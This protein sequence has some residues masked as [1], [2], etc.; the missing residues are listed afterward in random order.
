[1]A[2]GWLAVCHRRDVPQY[3]FPTPSPGYGWR[4]WK[5]LSGLLG[6]DRRARR[7]GE[8]DAPTDPGQTTGRPTG[9]GSDAVTQ[10]ATSS[11]GTA[12]NETYVGRVGGDEAGDVGRS[13]A[14]ARGDGDVD[15]QGAARRE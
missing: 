13:G 5:K 1:V 9:G 14:E 15:H 7:E 10:D 8:G 6:R 2:G 4:M 3:W 11:T 12:E